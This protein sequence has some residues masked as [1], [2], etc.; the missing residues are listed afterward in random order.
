MV[1]LPMTSSLPSFNYRTGIC[2]FDLTFLMLVKV[3]LASE[4]T[5]DT[6]GFSKSRS[7]ITHELKYMLELYEV[8]IDTSI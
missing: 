7:V 4:L 2:T 5:A 8:T 1:L 3:N 6:K